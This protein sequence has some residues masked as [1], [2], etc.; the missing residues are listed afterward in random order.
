MKKYAF[1]LLLAAACNSGETITT[2]DIEEPASRIVAYTP[3]PG[4]FINSPLA[5]FDQPVTTA[6]EAV[7]YAERRLAIGGSPDSNAS[8]AD[9]GYVSLGGWGGS[10]VAQFD[11]PVPNTGGYE[12]YVTGNSFDGSS[13]PGVVWVAQREGN[14]PG[15]WYQLRGSEYNHAETIHGYEA[16]YTLQ[17]D[18][19]IAWKDN[20]SPAASGTIERIAAHRQTSYIPAWVPELTYRGTR[21]RDNV[22]FDD[23]QNLYVMESFM[24]GYADNASTIDRSGVKNRFKISNAVDENGNTVHLAQ[25][26]YIKVQTGVNCKAGNGVGEISTEVCGIGCYRTVTKTE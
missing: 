7:A 24:W 16:T 26:D 12:L 22:T 6:A 11:T 19:S 21:L 25:I 1:F 3:A 5:G 20:L 13:E 8:S 18:G 17:A 4:Q 15:T 14:G 2:T 23:K 10:I 9:Y